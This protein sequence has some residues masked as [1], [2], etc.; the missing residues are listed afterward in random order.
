MTFEQRMVGDVAV[1]SINGDIAMNG[2]GANLLADRVREVVQAGHNR[3]ILDLGHVRYVDSAGVGELVHALSV[4][5]NRGGEMKL[6]NV[7]RRIGDLLVLTR[8]LTVF[9]CFD[10]EAQALASFESQP[11]ARV[12]ASMKKS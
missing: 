12:S 9:D 10:R 11:V 4:V 7:T 2:E 3:L 6:I 5:R 1:L 8:L